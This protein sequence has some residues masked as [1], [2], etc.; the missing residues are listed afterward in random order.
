MGVAAAADKQGFSRLIHESIGN[1]GD[2]QN[3]WLSRLIPNSVVIGA[4]NLA[5]AKTSAC[6]EVYGSS[7]AT[8]NSPM[9]TRADGDVSAGSHTSRIQ[10]SLGEILI[11][12]RRSV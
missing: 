1:M 8:A 12:N 10:M 7:T 6:G 11:R 2:G 9:L 4:A 3:P 5:T